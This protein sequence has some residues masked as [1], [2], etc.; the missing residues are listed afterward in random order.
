M[1]IEICG[2]TFGTKNDATLYFMS[3]F[4]NIWDKGLCMTTDDKDLLLKLLKTRIDIDKEV[5]ERIEDFRIISNKYN[6]FEVQYLFDK[7]WVPFSINRCVVGKTKTIHSK[8]MK[9]FRESIYDQIKI[10]QDTNLLRK[11]VFCGIMDNIQVDHQSPI[12]SVIVKNFLDTEELDIAEDKINEK[13]IERFKVYH[14][15]VASFRY[16]CQK[17]NLEE[18]NKTGRRKTM[19]DEEYKVKNRENAKKRYVKIVKKQEL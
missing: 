5:S 3:Y 12:F 7:T 13:V 19:T 15:S 11:C 17:H 8:T 1:K 10:F 14:K 4:R 6:T 2:K 9:L 16:L 18:F